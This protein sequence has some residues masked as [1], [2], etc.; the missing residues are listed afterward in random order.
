MDTQRICS[1]CGKP[2][3]ANAPEGLCPDCLLKAAIGT[4]VDL[5]ADTAAG[6]TNPRF[7]PPPVAEIAPL[8]PQL[9]ILEL[10]GHGGM[11]A[12]Y[13][14]RQ[15]ELD[16]CVA[17]KILPPG[18]GQT[19]AFA[20]RFTR[21]ARALAKLNH[22]GIV[23]IY[24]FGQAQPPPGA[25]PHSPPPLYYFLMEFV[26]GVNLRQLL[27]TKRVAPR[28]ALAIVP[29]ICDAL[30]YAHDQGIVHRDIKPENILMDRRGRVKVADFGL[31][32][33]VRGPGI[34]PADALDSAGAAGRSPGAAPALTEASKVMGTPQ[35]MSPEQ[36]ATPGEVDHRADI[37]ALGVVF[38]QMLTGELPGT[39]LE[40]PSAKVQIDVRL[41]EVVLR[42]LE[43]KPERRYQQASLLKTGIETIAASPLPSA[44]ASPPT[45]PVVLKRW[46]DL[47]PWDTG[48]VALFV[49]VPVVV[50]SALVLILMPIWGLQA[51]WL[52]SFELLGFGFAATYAWIGQRIRRLRAALPPTSGEIAEG[53]VLRRPFQSPGLA[54]LHADRLELIPITGS[55]TTL[56]LSDIVGVSEVR[57]F[58]G[59]WLWWKKGFILE[60]AD[61]RWVGLA[62]AEAFARRWRSRLSRGVLPEMP[63]AA[64]A[65]ADEPTVAQAPTPTAASHPGGT[66]NKSGMVR[67]AEALFG[68]K[69]RSALAVKL[70][71]LS[72]LGFLGFLSS[73]GFVPLSGMRA[74]FGFSAFFGFF[75]LIGFA[76]MVEIVARL[77]AKTASAGVLNGSVKPGRSLTAAL[78]LLALVAIGIDTT[79]LWMAIPSF[80]RARE[81]ASRRAVAVAPASPVFGA[82]REVELKSPWKR[83]AELFDLDTGLRTT[84]TTFGENDRETHAWIRSHRLDMLGVIEKGHSAILCFDLALVPVASNS[85]DSVTASDVSTN[86]SLGQQEPGKITAI[87]PTPDV[88]PSNTDTW[89][90]RTRE[91]GLGVLQ[92]LGPNPEG[93]AVR[94]RYKL[95][96]SPR[97]PEEVARVAAQTFGPVSG[98]VVNDRDDSSPVAQAKPGEFKVTLT[99]GITLEVVAVARNPRGTNFWWQPDGTPLAAPPLEIV[100]LPQLAPTT[101]SRITIIPHNEFLFHIRRELPPGVALESFQPGFTPRP[102]DIEL[103]ATVREIGGKA[104]ASAQLVCFAEPPDA[105]DYQEAV[106]CG[107][108]EAVSVYD[109]EAKTTRDL[110]RGVLALWSEPRYEQ[111][112]LR[113]DVMHNANREQSALR[114]VA[115]WRDGSS[116]T[117]VFQ[118]GVMTG[119]S[120]KGFALIH[121]SEQETGKWLRQVRELAIER[122]PWVRGE[123]RNI[124]LN[125]RDHQAARATGSDS[126]CLK[127]AE[128][129]A[130]L[131]QAVK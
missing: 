47:W 128:D 104:R 56:A 119:A 25:P 33:I 29:Q 126:L 100:K 97:A 21:E 18:I 34:E 12:V 38:Y 17:L 71:N 124:R 40:P 110:E 16:R 50:A 14:A 91:G 111:G 61:G 108:W 90:F 60:L 86:W 58:N 36:I 44:G 130:Q 99:D 85:W 107:P 76:F 113:F 77:K 8:F 69:F 45:A 19:P 35:Y 101:Q 4:G 78:A 37:Y 22:P 48:Y 39:P 127:S 102:S 114:M 63:P 75:G 6:A 13:Q 87:P 121:G 57:W 73:L 41:D 82:A 122:A 123:I 117:V 46:R 1:T 55:P 9:E 80:H 53:L 3:A 95:V 27:H 10:I 109:V 116:E 54:V 23:T 2:I 105:V 20:E 88:G 118:S 11:G 129:R 81:Q 65:S 115:R 93:T 5:G 24:D 70:L 62:V 30:Q 32:K 84:S 125:P 74:C 89:L 120:A 106:A 92:L 72:A 31:A 68:D 66:T 7:V 79:I 103:P 26:D 51:L 42:A 49:I 15:K 98:R 52:F 67:L 83:T 112:A 94:M 43:Q 28:E 96:A 131:R 64:P 59:R